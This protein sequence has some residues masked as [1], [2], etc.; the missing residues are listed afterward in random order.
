MSIK[1]RT[2][3]WFSLMV[4][5]IST[6]V[7]VF[8][9]VINGSSVTPDPA[10]RLVKI[11][12]GNA[13]DVEFD[14]GK[15]DWDDLHFYKRGVSCTFYNEAGERLRGAV[16]EGIDSEFLPLEADKLRSFSANG[17]TYLCYDTYVDMDI[18]GL[19]IRGIVNSADKSGLMHTIMV[20]T[21]TLLPSILLL[22]LGGGWLIVWTSFRPMDKILS[23]ADSISD[24]GDLS[25]RIALRRGPSEMKKLSQSFDRMFERLEKSFEAERQFTADASHELRTP[26]TVIL[27]QCDR[28]RRKDKTPEDF[29]SSLNVIQEQTEKM[30]ELVQQLLGLTRL[31]HGTDRYK[32]EKLNLSEFLPACAAD[33]MPEDERGIELQTDIQS[34]IEIRFN[35]A[36]MAR[37]VQNLLQNAYKYGKDG[38]HILLSLKKTDEG[39]R[40]S[41]K[42][43][44]IGIDS[45]DI[46]KIFNRFWQ[47][48]P[49]RNA[50]GGSGLGLSMVKEI[51]EFHG[52]SVSVQST[53]G[54]GST[55]TISI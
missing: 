23:A 47:A 26:I 52:G 48:D 44:G 6:M 2:V 7:L 21:F 31:Q 4:M 22:T 39:V 17:E 1:L 35:P 33:F 9:L 45:Q 10:E 34:G 32:L 3:L 43:D 46:D 20:L 11:V 28:A 36:L 5:L 53:P 16:I 30:S 15:F 42:D 55:F 38:G 50:G 54:E 12:L 37:A 49:A 24:G 8:V 40:I 25:A 41:V 13:D 27:A 51:A 29:R 19:W 18:S 14:N